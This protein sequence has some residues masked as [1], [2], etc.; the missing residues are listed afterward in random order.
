MSSKLVR[1]LLDMGQI[2][3]PATG[4]WWH[5]DRYEIRGGYICSAAGAKLHK[6]QPWERYRAARRS[7]DRVAAPFEQLLNLGRELHEY[8]KG[9]A[10]DGPRGLGGD[11]EFRDTGYLRELAKG[12][13]DPS[14]EVV[15][16]DWCNAHGLLG[17]LPHETLEVWFPPVWGWPGREPGDDILRHITTNIAV[18]KGEELVEWISPDPE[19]WQS[20]EQLFPC[21][22]HFTRRGGDWIQVRHLGNPTKSIELLEDYEGERRQGAL[23]PPEIREHLWAFRPRWVGSNDH[24]LVDS[25]DESIGAWWKFFP[26]LSPEDPKAY[27]AP[28]PLTPRFWS[29]YAEPVNRFLRAIW[30]LDRFLT[31]PDCNSTALTQ[32][33]APLTPTIVQ[34]NSGKFRME[35]RC[36]SLLAAFAMMA[37]ED[38]TQRGQFHQCAAERCGRIFTSVR[39]DNEYC[40]D[41]CRWR[42]QK[43]RYRER[44]HLRDAKKKRNTRKGP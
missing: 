1:H 37:V 29:I 12:R 20:M 23:V 39:S 35:Y 38:L 36:G 28:R 30:E 31:K 41:T 13:A 19:P 27:P 33:L 21:Q 17:I 10:R 22:K 43:R 44:A 7:S 4:S 18:Y 3:E 14:R 25:Q 26:T 24:G 42:Q 11:P 32:Y 8:Y 6:Y 5:F 34:G 16:I 2:L 40:S 15:L 9:L